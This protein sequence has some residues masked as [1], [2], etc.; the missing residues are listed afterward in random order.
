MTPND[1]LE[2]SVATSRLLFQMHPGIESW[3]ATRALTPEVSAWRNPEIESHHRLAL[4]LY[5]EE[6]TDEDEY[7]Y[8]QDT[9]IVE[10]HGLDIE[11]ELDELWF[12]DR[13][14]AF[15]KVRE[16]MHRLA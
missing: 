1:T 3:E 8:Q 5:Y 14:E 4:E 6:E 15:E 9:W 7:T 16:L 2:Q 10:H 11:E 12:Y 13:D